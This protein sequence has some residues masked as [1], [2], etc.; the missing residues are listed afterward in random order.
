MAG[1]TFSGGG[2]VPT[3][4]TGPPPT[5]PIM[6][7]PVVMP[8]HPDPYYLA[9]MGWAATLFARQSDE[10][11]SAEEDALLWANLQRYAD[12]MADYLR[13]RTAF[14]AARDQQR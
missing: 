3:A 11:L 8:D 14:A 12:A 10:P 9:A 1:D 2:F 6:G 13:Q 7:I 4:Q 5:S